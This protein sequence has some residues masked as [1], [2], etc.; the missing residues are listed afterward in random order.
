MSDVSVK[1]LVG[2]CFQ[3][4]NESSLLLKGYIFN[5]HMLICIT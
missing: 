5:C 3:C 2:I 4:C 1:N